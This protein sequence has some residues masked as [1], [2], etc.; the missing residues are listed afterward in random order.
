VVAVFNQICAKKAN[1]HNFMVKNNT[2]YV[3][4]WLFCRVMDGP[5]HCRLALADMAEP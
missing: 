5:I 1:F 4:R 2:F 3:E